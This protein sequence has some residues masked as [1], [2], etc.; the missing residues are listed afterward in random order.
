MI[1]T[2]CENGIHLFDGVCHSLKC[3]IINDNCTFIRWCVS[4]NCLK[5]TPLANKCKYRGE[6]VKEKED[7]EIVK[8]VKLIVTEKE[9]SKLILNNIIKEQVCKVC[10]I[11]GN[12]LMLDFKDYGIEIILDN[13]FDKFKL[14]NTIKVK[15][16]GE[17]GNPDFKIISYE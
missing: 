17:I 9:N 14:K 7:N 11:K 16:E 15:Y 8:D 6:I 1:L 10:F 2:L 13:N 3:N 5:M 4:D 12:K